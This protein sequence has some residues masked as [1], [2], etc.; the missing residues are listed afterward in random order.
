MDLSRERAGEEK[1]EER[2]GEICRRRREKNE[3]ERYP[4]EGDE[5][6]RVGEKEKKRRDSQ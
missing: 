6:D 3:G 4:E 1:Q 5:I 2:S